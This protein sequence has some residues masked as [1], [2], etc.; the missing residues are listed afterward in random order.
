LRRAFR[1]RTEGKVHSIQRENQPFSASLLR[2]SITKPL[3]SG[4]RAIPPRDC[5]WRRRGGRGPGDGA[6]SG[7]ETDG[8]RRRSTA[9]RYE[10][11]TTGRTVRTQR[12][13]E[14]RYCK[15]KYT[16]LVIRP[17]ARSLDIR[18][19][20]HSKSPGGKPCRGAAA[21]RAAFSAEDRKP[22]STRKMG[23]PKRGEHNRRS[24]RSCVVGHRTRRS[25]TRGTRSLRRVLRQLTLHLPSSRV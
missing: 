17:I 22:W 3:F 21:A 4:E 15:K 14:C 5:G 2:S 19:V 23:C 10:A 20:P 25:R 8:A 1:T 24:P 6:R 7:P 12:D 9:G 13:D 18:S 16:V 11:E